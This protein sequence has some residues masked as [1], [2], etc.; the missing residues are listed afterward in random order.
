ML[1]M[2]D[3]SSSINRHGRIHQVTC[4][5]AKNSVSNP[6]NWYELPD[7]RAAN[8]K[9]AFH[10]L[11]NRSP[12]LQTYSN[13]WLFFLIRS[14]PSC[15]LCPSLPLSPLQGALSS[16]FELAIESWQSRSERFEIH[17]SLI[18]YQELQG[19]VWVRPFQTSA[20]TNFPI[21]SPSTSLTTSF[22]LY[23]K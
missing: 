14:A 13:I 21:S 10:I 6:V 15:L 4:T 12:A 19:V 18:A 11:S 2:V 20:R 16:R 5:H 22:S 3:R 17:L 8:F 1:I 7:F 9:I 23:L